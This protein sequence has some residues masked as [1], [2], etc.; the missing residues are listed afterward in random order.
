M[1]GQNFIDSSPN[2]FGIFPRKGFRFND[3]SHACER[4]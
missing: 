3:L 4:P 1:P 2:E